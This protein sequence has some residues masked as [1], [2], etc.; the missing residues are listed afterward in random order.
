MKKHFLP[1]WHPQWG[2]LLAWPHSSTD[3]ADN[4]EAAEHCYA[5][6]I[7]A[8]TQYE[9]VLLLCHDQ[10]HQTHIQQ[11]LQNYDHNAS[12]IHWLHIP[13]D[14]TWAR[15]FAPIAVLNE[16]QPQFINF[17]FNAWGN[18]YP[19]ALDNAI[20]EQLDTHPLFEKAEMQ[21][22]ELVMEG[23]SL[24]TDG[25]GT[26]LTTEACLL[27]PNRN[28]TL[29]KAEIEQQLKQ[30]LGLERILWLKHGHLEGDD[31]D[32]HIDTLARFAS[33]E[34][35]VYITCN[36]TSDSHYADMKAMEAELKA[37]TQSNGQPYQLLPIPMPPAIYD[38][39]RRLGA[40]YV[41]YLVING[42]VLLPIYG[43]DAA[44]QFAIEQVQHAYPHLN[45]IPINCLALI[46]QN[47]SLHCITMQLPK[48]HIET[49]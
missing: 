29:N 1:E 30:S 11:C 10:A 15:D 17:T 37:L 18:K 5:Q 49:P 41:N 46:Q 7:S 8:I 35:I 33:P 27:N 39:G 43:D 3:W 42:A 32:A 20:N 23:G 14:D 2:V 34:S 40:S 9:Q 47:G 45:I 36:D 26:L 13:Y 25:Q 24:E 44:D 19:S 12:H 4:L 31:T 21:Q 28:P 38:E 22:H 6:I 16:E 48:T